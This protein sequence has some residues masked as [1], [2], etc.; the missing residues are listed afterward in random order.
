VEPAGEKPGRPLS[1]RKGKIK[2]K[3]VDPAIPTIEVNW[4]YGDGQ[5]Y[6]RWNDLLA[7]LLVAAGKGVILERLLATLLQWTPPPDPDAAVPGAGPH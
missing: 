7:F 2:V 3:L 4:M 1:E 6:V 5:V